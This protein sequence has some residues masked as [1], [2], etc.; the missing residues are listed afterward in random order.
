MNLDLL[1][2][3]RNAPIVKVRLSM[4]LQFLIVVSRSPEINSSVGFRVDV[5]KNSSMLVFTIFWT[6]NFESGET[7]MENQLQRDGT[8]R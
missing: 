8:Y 2:S 4:I 3:D 6:S 7:V 5:T 1:C